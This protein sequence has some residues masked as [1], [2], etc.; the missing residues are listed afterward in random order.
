M[1]P[2]QVMLD[3]PK[4]LVLKPQTIG[5]IL[6]LIS[7]LKYKVAKP[8]MEEI[9]VQLIQQEPKTVQQTTEAVQNAAAPGSVP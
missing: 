3:G 9:L 4:T 1:T 2:N 8:I 7:E 6:D 5:T